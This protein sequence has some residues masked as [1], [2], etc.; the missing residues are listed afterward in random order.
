MSDTTIA[1]KE[2]RCYLYQ[3]NDWNTALATFTDTRDVPG[4]TLEH[5]TAFE[6]LL[7]QYRPHIE[8]L[9]S[10][11]CVMGNDPVETRKDLVSV[12]IVAFWSNLKR[13]P[14]SSGRKISVT[15]CNQNLSSQMLRYINK[16]AR[17]VGTPEWL[18][19]LICKVKQ[20]VGEGDSI[21]AAIDDVASGE[22]K[23]ARRSITECLYFS[24]REQVLVSEGEPLES[25]VS[26]QVEANKSNDA[27]VLMAQLIE[28][29]PP[30]HADAV[31]MYYGFPPNASSHT[32]R[33]AGA[34]MKLTHERVRQLVAAANHMLRQKIKGTRQIMK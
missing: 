10:T 28:E 14:P 23:K 16:N 31:R 8:R 3:C 32:Y 18:A 30:R 9:A 2:N 29:L 21:A 34:K 15:M 11:Y 33:E 26:P 20:K 24:T 5:N 12:G 22:T 13:I 19:R 1:P 25:S 17:A 6:E 27:F 4:K 7:S